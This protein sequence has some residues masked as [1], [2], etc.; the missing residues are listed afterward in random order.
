VILQDAGARSKDLPGDRER[1]RAKHDHD[2]RHDTSG[3]TR[4]SMHE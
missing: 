3:L 4:R 2:G 1:I